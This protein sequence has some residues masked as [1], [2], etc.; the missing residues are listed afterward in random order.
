MKITSQPSHGR[1]ARILSACLVAAAAFV[2]SA[3]VQAQLYI[4]QTITNNIGE[5]SS[6]TAATPINANLVTGLS[7]GPTSLVLSGNTLFSVIPGDGKVVAYDAT[8]GAVLNANFIT[9]L[10]SPRGI[11]IS[12][13]TMYVSS[14]SSTIGTYNATTGAAINASFITSGP[15]GPQ[16]LAISGNSLFV[17]NFSNDTVGK[18]DATTGA[19]I[20]AAFL[21][22]VSTPVGLA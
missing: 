3:R 9:G 12:G 20:N 21:T 5:Y 7:G 10:S 18:F 16:G 14:S 22:G 11:L 2:L 13:N 15:S 4:G 19:V 17:A 6:T 1:F 8:T